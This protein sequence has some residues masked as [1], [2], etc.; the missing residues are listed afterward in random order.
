MITI[1]EQIITIIEQNAQI[2]ITI[3]MVITAG[4]LSFWAGYFCCLKDMVR[5]D[6]DTKKKIKT[7]T[8]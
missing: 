2:I 5:S 8:V 4:A 6:T 3:I 1:I 7:I